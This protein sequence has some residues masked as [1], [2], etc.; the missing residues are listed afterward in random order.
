M[1]PPPVVEL[2]VFELGPGDERKD[3]TFSYNANFFLFT[4]LE[5]ARPI[6]HGRVNPAQNSTPVLTGAPVAGMVYLDRPTPAGYFIFPDLSVR[7]EG[8]YRLS[9]SLY[10]DVKEDKDADREPSQNGQ[11]CNNSTGESN[12]L[13]PRA[14]VHFRLEVRSIAFAVFSAKKFPGLSESTNLS[15]TVAEQGCRVRIRRDVRMRR[16][17]K[18][19]DGYTSISDDGHYP[20]SDRYST[21]SHMPNRSRSISNGSVDMQTPYSTLSRRTSMQ[22]LPYYTQPPS[23]Q[24]SPPLLPQSQ[25]QSPG[26]SSVLYGPLSQAS[27]RAVSPAPPPLL[28]SSHSYSHP[29]DYSH[30]PAVSPSRRTSAPQNYSYHQASPQQGNS[31]MG[32]YGHHDEQR[33]I[34]EPRHSYSNSSLSSFEREPRTNSYD[35]YVQNQPRINPHVSQQQP[36]SRSLTPINTDTPY[37]S[38]RPNSIPSIDTLLPPIAKADQIQAPSGPPPGPPGPPNPYSTSSNRSGQHSSIAPLTVAP[39]TPQSTTSLYSSDPMSA[40]LSS[41]HSS[42]F[43]DA[44]SRMMKRTH[45]TVFDQSNFGQPSTFTV[46]RPDALALNYGQD[47]AK[48]QTDDGDYQDYHPDELMETLVYKRANGQNAAK[49]NPWAS[50]RFR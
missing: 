50:P 1:D 19:S 45:N 2:K 40:R 26:N 44:S 5:P 4:T 15:R 46:R 28:H 23:Y 20:A 39:Y 29:S 9:F 47:T 14:H 30:Y 41:P 24:Q 43:D 48:I 13:A 33:M 17:D 22:E 11:S 25:S 16:R 7:H 36:S 37:N 12:S 49:K 32:Q 6:N 38:S 3:I 8:M 10:E 31:F 21:P 42:M 35:T 27:Q 18:A 34:P